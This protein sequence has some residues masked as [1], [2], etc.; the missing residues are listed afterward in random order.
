MGILSWIIIGIIAG[1][2][3]KLVIRGEGP[4]GVLGDLLIGV[5]GALLGG[6]IWTSVLH[7]EGLSGFSWHSLLI[8]FVG[9]VILL[10]LLRLFGRKP[11]AT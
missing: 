6:F 2:L 8:A 11:A 9:S 1:F 3:A 5:L 4:G 10:L 7:R